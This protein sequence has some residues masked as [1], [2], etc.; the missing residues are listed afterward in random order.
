MENQSPKGN[1]NKIQGSTPAV[2][3]WDVQIV[4][5]A[6]MNQ[7]IMRGVQRGVAEWKKKMLIAE[8]WF[9]SIR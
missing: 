3:L 1:N 5:S 2:T 4:L 8:G 7:T 6:R 9:D